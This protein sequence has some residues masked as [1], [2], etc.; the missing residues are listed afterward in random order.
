MWVWKTNPRL[1]R[2]RCSDGETQLMVWFLLPL[3]LRRAKFL[4]KGKARF[5]ERRGRDDAHENHMVWLVAIGFGVGAL[6]L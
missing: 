6:R 3:R 2:V 1:T 4:G 5:A